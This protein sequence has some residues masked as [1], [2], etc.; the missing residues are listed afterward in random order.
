L[1]QRP[2]SGRLPVPIPLGSGGVIS[3]FLATLTGASN[4]VWQGGVMPTYEG[5]RLPAGTLRLERGIAEIT[6][7]DGARVL[8]EGPAQFEIMSTYSGFLYD[9]RLVARVASSGAGFMVQTPVVQVVDLGT[10]FGVDVSPLG[11]V[12]VFCFEGLIEMQPM[13]RDG[14]GF[15]PRRL[16]AGELGVVQTSGAATFNRPDAPPPP[17]VRKPPKHTP[18]AQRGQVVNIDFGTSDS[19]K[20]R[21]LGVYSGPGGEAANRFWNHV[22]PGDEKSAILSAANGDKTAVTIT[23]FGTS[24]WYTVYSRMDHALLDDYIVVI[25]CTGRFVIGGLMPGERYDLYLFGTSGTSNAEQHEIGYGAAEGALFTIGSQTKA[26][27]GLRRGNR[28]FTIGKDYVVFEGVEASA[29]GEIRGTWS[30]NPQANSPANNSPYGILNGM[31]IVGPMIQA[32]ESSQRRSSDQA[33]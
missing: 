1:W 7:D 29:D 22:D 20:Y 3:P 21:G 4:C 13:Q 16:T 17:F 12:E 28:P 18:A 14:E 5:A 31:Q 10:E 24:P 15:Q 2:R 11:A 27:L 30:P 6:F 26:T 23:Y 19:P 33:L 32:T 25:N 9:G 8:L